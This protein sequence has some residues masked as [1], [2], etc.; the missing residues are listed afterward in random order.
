MNSLYVTVSIPLLLVLA[1]FNHA[2]GLTTFGKSN[3]QGQATNHQPTGTDVTIYNIFVFDISF[4]NKYLSFARKIFS[5]LVRHY[6][7]NHHEI[8]SKLFFCCFICFC[9]DCWARYWLVFYYFK[10]I[11]KT[12]VKKYH[13]LKSVL[14][15]FVIKSVRTYKLTFLDCLA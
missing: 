8:F 15:K 9:S 11:I 2:H 6:S 5:V 13:W 10:L 14:P 4:Y 12:F 7:W 1:G 3:S